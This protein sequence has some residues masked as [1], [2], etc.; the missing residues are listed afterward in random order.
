MSVRHP[1]TYWEENKHHR[2]VDEFYE[3]KK[4]YKQDL[5]R[6]IRGEKPEHP[7]PLSD[8]FFDC[9]VATAVYGNINAPQVE[10]LRQF[11]DNVL[12]NSSFGRAFINFYYSGSGEK[13]AK[14]IEKHLPST[15]PILRKSLDVLVRIYSPQGK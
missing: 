4:K 1:L 7:F 14:F 8:E 10:V 11:R 5:R 2:M 12:A 6:G 15:I 9:F 3:K 13:T